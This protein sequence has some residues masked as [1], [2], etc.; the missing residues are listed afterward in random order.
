MLV[1]RPCC[2]AAFLLLVLFICLLCSCLQ[3]FPAFAANNSSHSF[4]LPG[5]SLVDGRQTPLFLHQVLTSLRV[6]AFHDGTPVPISFQVDG[7]DRRGRWTLEWGKQSNAD[8]P[9]REFD[10]NDALVFMNRDLGQR[11][12]L[13]QLPSG[14]TLWGEVR[15]GSV[16]EP[17]GFVYVGVF[18]QPPPLVC[19][20]CVSARYD[21]ANDRVYAERYALEFH[22]P[23]PTHIAFVE[24]MGEFGENV[25]AGV[26]GVVDV[27]F[28]GGLL[29]LHRT[30]ADIRAEL[31]GYRNGP[32]RTLRRARYWTPLPLG[33]HTTGQVDLLFYR[34]FVE[35]TALL[36]IK[37]PPKL[38]LASGEL[39]AYFDFLKQNGARVLL[40][41]GAVGE[42]V[43]GRMTPA[44]QQLAGRAARWAALLLPEGRTVLFIVRLEGVLQRL[45]QQ[46]YF[47]DE[48]KI[49][50]GVGGR[51]LFGFQF[52]HVDQ[53]QTGTHQ[54]SVFACVLESVAPEDIRRTAQMFLSPPEVTVT[55]LRSSS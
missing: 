44:K 38:I 6:Y 37:I 54:L 41:D 24:K 36:K 46:L 16:N 30:D 1:R 17:L 8:N 20:E 12:S 29:T 53:L 40:E 21:E 26:H 22:A 51:P 28:L 49:D 18:P 33:L 55:P 42:P 3:L 19:V 32:V 52:T 35:G 5:V 9:T 14:A 2:V 13:A 45:E 25:V 34:D 10:E 4:T 31:L 7:R 43:D 47:D 27:R 39:Q 23:L 48:T 15:V 50:K 11:G